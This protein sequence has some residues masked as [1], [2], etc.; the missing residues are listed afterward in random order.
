MKFPPPTR[1]LQEFFPRRI[2]PTSSAADGA[3][4]IG[5][6]WEENRILRSVAIE[7][8]DRAVVRHRVDSVAELVGR[9]RLAGKMG[10]G[11]GSAGKDREP[12]GLAVRLPRIRAGHAKVVVG[13]SRT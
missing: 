10:T 11:K 1:P 7:F 9:I 3:G 13:C 2:K 12:L 6:Q 8:P 5:L 4:S